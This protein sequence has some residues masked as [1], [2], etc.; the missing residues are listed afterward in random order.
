MD[1]AKWIT[2]HDRPARQERK[3][4]EMKQ[5]ENGTTKNIV[6]DREERQFRWYSHVMRLQDDKS[7]KRIVKWNP[8]GTRKRGRPKVTWNEGDRTN[9]KK[10]NINDE[11]WLGRGKRKGKALFL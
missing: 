8:T 9:M 4:L 5:K 6:L 2:G 1:N 10:T 3:K 11:E 7:V